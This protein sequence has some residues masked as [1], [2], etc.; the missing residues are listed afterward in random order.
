MADEPKQ[1]ELEITEQ[2]Y[3]LLN[4]ANASVTAANDRQQ[5]ILAAT[6]AMANVGNAEIAGV[7]RR[8][9]RLLLLYTV[10]NGKGG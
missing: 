4:A 9:G 6:L 1:Q 5:A 8:D 7:V 2:T 3:A 10:P